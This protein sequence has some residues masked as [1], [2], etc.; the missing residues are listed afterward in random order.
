MIAPAGRIFLAVHTGDVTQPPAASRSCGS[1]R[2]PSRNTEVPWSQQ[3]SDQSL[4]PGWSSIINHISGSF[5]HRLAPGGQMEM[6]VGAGEVSCFPCLRTQ[7][8]SFGVLQPFPPPER[9]L[10]PWNFLLKS[11]DWTP[12]RTAPICT[13]MESLKGHWPWHC[14]PRVPSP[15]SSH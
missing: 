1:C 12:V 5:L 2:N 7:L 15:A 9:F 3:R 8:L 4:F 6:G 14:L 13:K 10:K 11:S